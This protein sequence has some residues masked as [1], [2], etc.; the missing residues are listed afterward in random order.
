MPALFDVLRAKKATPLFLARDALTMYE[1]AKYEAF[2]RGESDRR[3][4]LFYQPG[5]QSIHS[6]SRRKANKK[7]DHVLHVTDVLVGD[8]LH[9]LIEEKRIP[10]YEWQV[11]VRDESAYR[12]IQRRFTRYLSAFL[13]EDG[14]VRTYSENLYQKFKKLNIPHDSPLIIVDTNATGRTAL[15]V[16]TVIE[17]FSKEDRCGFF[18]TQ[19]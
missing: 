16:K 8:I 10:E 1:F 12:E 9:E 15:Y 4:Y 6:I 3:A 5:T 14:I 19:K 18:D 17:Y 2:L 11:E 13:D 7:L